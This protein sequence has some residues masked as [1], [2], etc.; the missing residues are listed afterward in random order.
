MMRIAA[1]SGTRQDVSQI[2]SFPAVRR[3]MRTK[4][5]DCNA[6]GQRKDCRKSN[7]V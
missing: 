7:P 5:P 2:T 3:S 6:V 1:P 4:K